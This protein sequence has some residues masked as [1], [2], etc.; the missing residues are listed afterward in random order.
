MKTKIGILIAIG[1]LV[2]APLAGITGTDHSPDSTATL[3]RAESETRTIPI[4]FSLPAV[5][6]QGAYLAVDCGTEHHVTAAGEPT[7]PY[8]T[9]TMT[10]PLG[11]H[12]EDVQVSV[13]D[14]DTRQLTGKVAPA[15]K[16]VPLNM[17]PAELIQQE[18]PAYQSNELYPSEWLRWHT[19]AG[20]HNGGHATFLTLQAFPA[21]YA[22]QANTLYSVDS[23]DVT[24]TIE[25]PAQPVLT[26][27]EYDMLIV[28]P[29]EFTDALQPLVEHKNSHGV[30]TRL[31]TLD[32]IYG[33]DIF[34]VEG[35]D[36]QEKIKYFIKNALEDWG[37]SYVMLVGGMEGQ[38]FSYYVPVRYTNN[39][40]GSPY[41]EGFISDLYYADVYKDVDGEPVFAD[42]DS[43]GNGVFAE[44]TNMQKDV[45]DCRP[46]V[47]LGRL[48]CRSLDDV[49]VMVDKIIT[50]E[51]GVADTDWFNRMLL[52]G[53]D[54]YPNVGDP[55]A[56]E[57]EIDTNLSG[58]YMED[59]FSLERLWASTG[60]LTGQ[61]DVEAAINDGAG[62]IHMAGH[63][64]PGTLVTHPPKS[65]DSIVILDIYNI[66]PINA[67][68]ALYSS[69][70][71]GALEQLQA[72]W[73]P[74]LSNGDKLPVV[75]VGGCHNSQ[76]NTSVRNI[77]KYGFT[78]AYGYGIHVPKC[79]SWWLTSLPEGGSIA[80]LGNTGLG[81]GIP[82]WDYV[83]GLDGWLFPRFFYHYGV[84]DVDVVGTLQGEATTDYVNT[85]AVNEGDG[86]VRQMVT[87]W[88]LFGDP[89]LKIGGYP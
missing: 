17:Q 82:A 63:A 54:T 51:G 56:Y 71:S 1:V 24:V 41:E 49:E 78:H 84:N 28:T 74:S 35:R 7:L 20:L 67:L 39:H 33:G 14:M 34:A 18:G 69:G 9:H 11:T 75:V 21:R 64:N 62:L 31:V 57:A 32:E 4:R 61:A 42:W 40:A 55:D 50:Y 59:Q 19:G 48:A 16:P 44:F 76:F 22:P 15:P 12:I 23:I 29:Q 37:I 70:I 13:G 72:S 87:Q 53:G 6:A 43:N 79:W 45:L 10:F 65:E 60:T 83:T 73:M 26:A 47:Y 86:A 89:S 36:D 80:T 66:P 77:L 8:T 5:T 3:P 81:M 30:A 85:F 2:I 68:W 46:D 38:S 25:R 88:S 58:S 27:D 52:I